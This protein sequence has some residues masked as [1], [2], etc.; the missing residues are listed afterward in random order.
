MKVGIIGCSHSAGVSQAG[1][2]HKAGGF[3]AWKGWP[4]QLAKKFPQHE[5]HLFASPGGGQNN[6]EAALRTC[7]IE[8]F[9]MVILQFT[10]QRQMWPL[11]IERKSKK[12]DGL[13]D[14]W[15]QSGKKDNFFLHQQR[16]K[17]LS[18]K[19]YVVERKCVMVGPHWDRRMGLNLDGTKVNA[20]EL[21]QVI[22]DALLDNQYFNE[23]AETF[24]NCR[25]LYKKMF[26]HFYSLLWVPTYKYGPTNSD[27]ALIEVEDKVPVFVEEF[28]TG[29]NLTD[30]TD[31]KK[32]I[33][34]WLVN[35]YSETKGVSHTDANHI[36]FHEYKKHKGHLGE[37]GQR[38]VLNQYLLKHKE[39]RKA[40]DAS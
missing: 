18:V 15:F 36:I 40:L 8:D 31:W 37:K 10:T 27:Q 1:L 39:F 2:L 23:M 22:L 38:E 35:Y 28:L 29:K 17:C 20:Y 30:Q 24:Y 25:N 19:N 33:Y 13:I 26:K 32:T 14:S 16:M 9:G 12:R 21:P 11:T 34:D 7:L 5:F 4:I 3:N 6:M